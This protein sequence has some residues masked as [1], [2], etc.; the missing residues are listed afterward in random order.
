MTTISYFQKYSQPENH[1]TNNTLLMLRHL[2]MSSST[3]FDELISELCG[4]NCTVGLK[5]Q[6]QITQRNRNCYDGSIVQQPIDITV[7][8]KRG[9]NLDRK[10]I[11]K[12]VDEISQLRGSS[13]AKHDGVTILIGVTTRELPPNELNE[14]SSYAKENHV[15]FVSIT[16]QILQEELRRVCI[17]DRSNLREVYLD[18]EEYLADEGV[19]E[20]DIMKAFAC[21]HN[22]E[23]N[24]RHRMYTVGADTPRYTNARIIG[25]N[26]I[27]VSD[28]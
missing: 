22:L 18:F 8:T 3:K 17:S 25:F 15:H 14:L 20:N 19:L 5:F 11:K 24:V 7:E 12:Y 28:I 21:R 6:Q 27:S 26:E 4:E 10:Q 9:P 1:L 23:L 16:F 2:Y 13:Y